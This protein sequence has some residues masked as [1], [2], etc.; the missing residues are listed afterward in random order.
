M[1]VLGFNAEETPK[2]PV[3]FVR[4]DAPV[5]SRSP[6]TARVWHHV[7]GGEVGGAG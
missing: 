5:A 1:L 6:V 4:T 3:E 7:S 2:D